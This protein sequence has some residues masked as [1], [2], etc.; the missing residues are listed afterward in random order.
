MTD[1]C[2]VIDGGV[3]C[4]S[5]ATQ[6]VAVRFEPATDSADVFAETRKRLCDKHAEWM[7]QALA[8]VLDGEASGTG[9]G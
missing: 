4:A 9:K 3:P 6:H 1:F 5:P 7:R 2:E 8:A